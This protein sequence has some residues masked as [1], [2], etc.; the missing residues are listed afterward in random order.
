MRRFLMAAVV[1]GAVSAAQAADLPI[2]RGGFTDGYSSGRASWQGFYVGG[3][4]SWG[5]QKSA[6][7]GIGDMQAS[8]IT[9]A[10]VAPY[11]FATPPSTANSLN[12]GYGAFSGYNLQYEDV[13]IGIEGNYIHDG[14]RATSAAGRLNPGTAHPCSERDVLQRDDEV[15]RFRFGAAAWRLHDGMF[16]AL[17]FCGRRLRRPDRRPRR[18]GHSAPGGGRRG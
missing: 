9:P 4:G 15:I 13:V 1:F 16:P 12:G 2:L 14:F 17:H 11:L 5:S 6:L 10:G 18:F 8:F 7:P 3:Q